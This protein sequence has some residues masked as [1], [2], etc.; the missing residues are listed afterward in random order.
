MLCN[1]RSCQLSTANSQL[2]AI[3][4]RLIHDEQFAIM[5]IEGI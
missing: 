5:L 2:T 3:S 1:V 4:Y